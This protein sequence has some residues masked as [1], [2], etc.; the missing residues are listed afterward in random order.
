MTSKARICWPKFLMLC[1]SVSHAANAGYSRAAGARRYRQA[2]LVAGRTGRGVTPED[3]ESAV[4]DYLE[5]SC[6]ES[7]EPGASCEVD[8]VGRW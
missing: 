5:T 6:K 8:M 7:R 3:I 4:M 1:R 2:T